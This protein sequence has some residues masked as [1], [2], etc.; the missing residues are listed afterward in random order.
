MEALASGVASF[1]L[2]HLTT[3]PKSKINKKLPSKKFSRVQIFPRIS[4]EAKNRVFHFHHWM[5]FTPLYFL[6]QHTGNAFLQSSL[7]HGF[8]LGGIVQGLLFA[9]RFRIVFHLK[10]YRRVNRSSYNLSFIKKII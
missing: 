3:H 10:E 6:T 5:I 7:L 8:L 1:I 2:F 4:I 9:D